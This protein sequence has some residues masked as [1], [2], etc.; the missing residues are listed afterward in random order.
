MRMQPWH[1]WKMTWKNSGFERDSNPRPLRYRCNALP[2][3]LS[4]L[5][6][7]GRVWVRPFMF[8]GRNTRL[9]YMNSMVIDVQQWQLNGNT[10]QRTRTESFL[11]LVDLLWLI[12]IDWKTWD[13]P[14]TPLQYFLSTLYSTDLSFFVLA[15]R[16]KCLVSN[17]L[18]MKKKRSKSW[19]IPQQ[20]WNHDENANDPGDQIHSQY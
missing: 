19:A 14:G 10:T 5:H 1:Y 18:N 9:G 4:K 6:E 7:S 20:N 15:L 8:S 16:F 11:M 12:P 13:C 17:L 2:T 3:E